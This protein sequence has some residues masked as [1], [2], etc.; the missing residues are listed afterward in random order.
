MSVVRRTRGVAR[1]VVRRI[2]TSDKPWVRKAYRAGRTAARLSVNAVTP[3]QL[4]WVASLQGARW[5][6]PTVLEIEGWA[7][8]R[9]E[10]FGEGP[11]AS[12]VWRNR[13]LGV[14]LP[15]DVRMSPSVEANRRARNAAVDY[16]TTGF[17]ARVDVAPLVAVAAA[18]GK[19]VT[20]R[21]HIAVQGGGRRRTGWFR[22]YVRS[23]SAGYV[24]GRVVG[25]HLVTPRWAGR[26][27]LVLDVGSATVGARSAALVGRELE[28]ELVVRGAPLRSAKL[29]GPQGTTPL[30]LV[31]GGRP[32]TVRV[33]G[34]V[35][36]IDP[37]RPWAGGDESIPREFAEGVAESHALTYVPIVHHRLMVSD[38]HGHWHHVYREFDET[39][40]APSQEGALFVYPGPRGDLRVRDTPLQ[41]MV[42]EATVVTAPTPELRLAGTVHGDASGLRLLL[43]GRRQEL[44]ARLEFGPDGTYT[45]VIPLLVSTWGS[46]PLAPISGRYVLIG[47]TA[48]GLEIRVAATAAVAARTPRESTCGWFRV[49]E[50]MGPGRHLVLRI[51]APLADDEVGSFHQRR[52]EQKY[53]LTQFTPNESVYLE[54]FYGRQATCNPLALDRALAEHHP[55]LAR[56]WGVVDRSVWTPEGATPVVEGTRAWWQAR[57]T[58]RYV[59]ANDWLRRRFIHQPHQVVLQT[60]HGSML[61][62]IGLDRPSAGHS[63]ERSLRL[64]RAKWDLLLSQNAHSTE[65]FKTAYDWAEPTVEE[66]YP[67]NDLMVTGDGA[68]I[69]RRLGI[70]DD[71]VAVLYAPTWRDNV[72]GLVTY[73][74]LEALARELGPRYVILLRGH[75]RTMGAGSKVRVPGVLD[76][77]TYPNVTELFLASDAMITDYSSVMFDFSVTGRPLIFFV[78]DMDDYRDSVRGVYFDLSEVAP[79]PVLATQA[80]VVEA[81]RSMEQDV[82]RYAERYAAWRTR[83]NHL[84]DGTSAVRVMERLLSTPPRARP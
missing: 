84:D 74:D 48:E 59:I 1:K 14:G 54:S 17:V 3:L 56:Y 30:R 61:K 52:L 37:A 47:L 50:M 49:R 4:G 81:I 43:K 40:H 41:L 58:A 2:S 23:G 29:E 75:S 65:I 35:P 36:P 51:S 16:S 66:G 20:F 82:A 33:V 57:G 42:R 78:P 76:V 70:A 46:P 38:T 8:E 80:E 10:D 67:R 19:T 44:E 63:T 7:Y 45:A 12:L 62:R 55:E 68:E 21:A 69:R 39:P 32:G 26:Q 15:M 79:G 72:T 28:A 11:R 27:G 13:S 34:T 60:W 22:S 18:R 5:V 71:Q 6:G 25:D 53:R 9:G 77:T 64:E 83:F 73:L 31:E 24:Q